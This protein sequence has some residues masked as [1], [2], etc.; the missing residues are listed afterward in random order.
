MELSSVLAEM[1]Y[2][3]RSK[4]EL[5]APIG[6]LKEKYKEIGNNKSAETETDWVM[7]ELRKQALG[8]IDLIE[9]RKEILNS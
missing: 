7:G 6:F 4:S 8:N 9:L 1:K 2:K 5:I 3:K